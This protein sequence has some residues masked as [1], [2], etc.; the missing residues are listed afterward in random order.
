MS[1]D[2]LTVFSL[3]SP[4]ELGFVNG[5]CGLDS[6]QKGLEYRAAYHAESSVLS[7]AAKETMK[8]SFV[9]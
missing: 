5:D 3:E 4:V 9:K 8:V 2:A 6:A 7:N 1:T